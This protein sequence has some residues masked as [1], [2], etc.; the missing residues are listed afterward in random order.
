MTD[1]TNSTRQGWE[2]LYPG[3]QQP[4]I[5][6]LLPLLGSRKKRILVLGT[7]PDSPHQM[8]DREVS[9]RDI[10]FSVVSFVFRKAIRSSLA[11]AKAALRA[12]SCPL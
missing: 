5:H 9:E 2:E 1:L 6:Y 12:L 3:S 10:L 8:S 7:L 11:R 4:H